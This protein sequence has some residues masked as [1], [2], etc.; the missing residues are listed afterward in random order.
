V[1]RSK[2]VARPLL[3]LL[4]LC[5]VVAAA[6]SLH[7]QE[8]PQFRGPDGQGHSSERG[9]PTEWS[10]SKNVAWKVAVPGRGW[11]SPV[12]ADGKVW[13]TTATQAGRDSS[14]RL[15]S[16]DAATGRQSVDVEVFRL[17]NS[18]LLN[19]KNSHA[20]PT[21]IVEGDRVY[22]HFGAQG[23]AAL[24]TTGEMI[25]KARQL[26]ESQHGNGGSPI[27]FGDL[28]IFSC[29]GFDEAFV[30]A[31]DKRTGKTR[32][33]TSRPQPW[34]QAYSTPLAIHAADRDQIVSVGAFHTVAYD[35][36]NGKE[37]WRVDYPEGFSNVPRP[38]FGAGLV[39]ITTGF[40]QPSLLAVR[41]DGNGD[42]T[43]SHVAWTLSRAA[44]LTPSPLLVGDELYVVTD[45][46]I[47]SSVDARTGAIHWQHRLG[48]GV[49]ASPVLADGRIYFL[50][51][52]GRTTVIA[53]GKT[54]QQVA[55]NVLEGPTLASMA[56][57]SQSFYIRTATHLYRIASQDSRS[58][59]INN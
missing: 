14:L 3:R 31:L 48:E 22:V 23:T 37:I 35:P 6:P 2:A 18:T 46:G 27:L 30:V 39:F 8:W 20:S 40:Q 28:L 7:A 55:M 17:K 41:P 44:P 38:V 58:V 4:V 1:V 19:P 10:E 54:F 56:V 53:P 49:S 34:S 24:S 33:R 25:W 32:W 12:V 43:K 42:V 13:L 5:C 15:L 26:Y 59:I 51:E 36:Q 21:P 16:F 47:A 50:D 9:L 52:E 57:A 45:A 11:S 29:D